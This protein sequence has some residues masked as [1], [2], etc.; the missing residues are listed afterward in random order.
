MPSK[1]RDKYEIDRYNLSLYPAWLHAKFVAGGKMI[2]L[3]NLYG[4]FQL[5]SDIQELRDLMAD[6]LE[7]YTPIQNE[8]VAK[9]LIP[10]A[11]FDGEAAIKSSSC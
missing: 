10:G 8:T 7:K 11:S 1:D 5:G 6:R 2:R 3:S 4:L 9:R